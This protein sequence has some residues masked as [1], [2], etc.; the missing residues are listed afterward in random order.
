MISPHTKG[1][2]EINTY[3]GFIWN[4]IRHHGYLLTDQPIKLLPPH[5]APK[6]ILG[7]EKNKVKDK[8]NNLFYEN[9]LIHFDLFAQ[10]CT[11]LLTQSCAIRRLVSRMYPII[12]LDEFQDTN[13]DEWDLIK[14]LGEGSHLIVLADPNQR[15]YDFREPILRG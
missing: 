3:H 9:G 2:I 14:L 13:Q 7:I 12:I 11:Q 5:E 4:I 1:Q 15:I 8:L 10:V 6:Y